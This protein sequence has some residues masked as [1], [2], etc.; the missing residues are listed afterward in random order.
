MNQEELKYFV[1]NTPKR[2]YEGFCDS[3]RI[4]PEGHL[5]LCP[6]QSILPLDTDGVATGF[7]TDCHGNI[8][9]ID[10]MNCRILKYLKYDKRYERLPCIGE[11]GTLPG[12]FSFFSPD[13]AQYAGWLALGQK[14]L[15]VADTFN[16]RIQAFYLCNF[17]LRYVIGATDEC[18]QPAAGKAPGQFNLPGQ[19]LFDCQENLY[20]LDTGNKRI[21]K[22]DRCG[23][24]LK[25][26]AH[27][28]MSQPVGIA[29]DRC[30]FLYAIDGKKRCVIK[31]DELGGQIS[32]IKNLTD[33]N[34]SMQPAG[35]AVDQNGIIYIGE[36]GESEGLK[37]YILDQEGNYLGSFGDYSGSCYQLHLDR[38]NTL[39]A[40]C[41]PQNILILNGEGEYSNSGTYCSKAFDSGKK[42]TRW[43]KVVVDGDVPERTRAEVLYYL[44]ENPV[45]PELIGENDWTKCLYSPRNGL[46]S[47][48]GLILKGSGQYLRL[49]VALYGDEYHTPVIRSIQL[50]FPRISY[51]RYLPAT[52]QEDEQGRDFM[53]R[54]LSIFEALSSDMENEIFLLSKYFDPQATTDE[55]LNW[56]GAWLAISKDENWPEQ[57]KRDLIQKAYRLYKIRGTLSGLKD[58]VE[59]YTEKPTLI[60]EHF[61]VNT[62]TIIGANSTIGLS[63]VVGESIEQGLVV[64]ESSTLGDFTLAEAEDPPEAPFEAFAHDFSIYINISNLENDRQKQRLKTIIEEDKPAHTRCFIY[65]SGGPMMIG[66]NSIVEVSTIIS[67]GITPMRLGVDS[68]I[69]SK[70]ILGTRYPTRGTIG[71]RS[72]IG[73]ETVVN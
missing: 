31:F 11:C 51:L 22:F 71:A 66:L 68:I 59:F 73:I 64:E 72:N 58:I 55:M 63:T 42:G 45:A 69:G 50:C 54:F 52:Y 30:N 8:F 7:A 27:P 21:Q 43:H 39:Y 13:S 18:R 53:E 15:Y 12:Q 29:L 9:V 14:I 1:L 16:H 61:L 17:Q 5:S 35:I 10:A 20:V 3:V 56:L 33:I 44:S 67:E 28:E 26:F 41:G 49:K 57:K 37:I 47:E 62:P 19:I 36:K 6:N 23:R 34:Q 32:I 60:I 65:S 70:S 38:D 46:K 24:L 40:N 2:W 25:I 4:H 48:Q